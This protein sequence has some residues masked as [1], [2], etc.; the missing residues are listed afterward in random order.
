MTQTRAIR[1]AFIGQVQAATSPAI[2]RRVGELLGHGRVDQAVALVVENSATNFANAMGAVFVDTA[3]AEC[4]A[5]SRK[6]VLRKAPT[7]ALSFNVAD[8]RAVRRLMQANR[9]S[10]IHGLTRQQQTAVRAR[11]PRQHT[12]PGR[13]Y[14]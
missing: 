11:R 1:Q 4:A 14:S 10:Y 3:S 12:C 8:E 5:L 7:V 2:M 9:L 13:S 6:L